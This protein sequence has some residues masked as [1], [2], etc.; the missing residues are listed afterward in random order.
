MGVRDEPH[1]E[2]R[3]PQVE[4]DPEVRRDLKGR[5]TIRTA[6][7]LFLLSAIFELVLVTAEA[8]WF[9]AMRGGP[10]IVLYH[11]LFVAVFVGMG[12][13]LWTG[14]RWGYWTV[15]AGT[16]IYSLDKIR[17]LLDRQGRAAEI[18]YQLR[19]FPDITDVL[20]MSVLLNMS[21][22]MTATFVLCWWGFAVYIYVRMKN[23]D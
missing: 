11:L 7:V 20:D 21:S 5:F 14:T 3:Q 17:Y 8:P 10:P 12:L 15:L 6:A 13:G 4:A 9:G 16:A 22:I 18:L 1:R 2:G 19:D 23:G